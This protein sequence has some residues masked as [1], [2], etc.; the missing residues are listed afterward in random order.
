MK[1]SQYGLHQQ[2]S[3][4]FRLVQELIDFLGRIKRNM[5]G[6]R[7]FNLS[8]DPIWLFFRHR[9]PRLVCSGYPFHLHNKSPDSKP[10][11]ILTRYLLMLEVKLSSLTLFW[12]CWNTLISSMVFLTLQPVDKCHRILQDLSQVF[13]N[14]SPFLAI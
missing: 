3:P 10:K 7:G 14:Y 2:Q 4:N 13:E 6:F 12:Y 8:W 11:K 9:I 1:I 5:F